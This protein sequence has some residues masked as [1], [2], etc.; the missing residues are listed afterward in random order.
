MRMRTWRD[1]CSWVIVY[2]VKRSDLFTV[3][4]LICAARWPN[5]LPDNLPLGMNASNLQSTYKSRLCTRK[6]LKRPQ[7]HTF[8]PR[9]HISV[10]ADEYFLSFRTAQ[11]GWQ[12]PIHGALS[13]IAHNEH[14]FAVEAPGVCKGI[15][16]LGIDHL[17]VSIYKHVSHGFA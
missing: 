9:N 5:L 11:S 6:S 17:K 7:C 10:R 4:M 12:S 14:C 15:V 16:V 13:E 2:I 3:R 1:S 8:R